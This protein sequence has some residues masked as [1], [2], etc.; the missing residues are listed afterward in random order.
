MNGKPIW[1]FQ[2]TSLLSSPWG[3]AVSNQGFVFV[4]G[5]QPHNIVVILP[6]GN[7][8]K[9]EYQISSPRAMCYD[10]TNNKILVCRTDSKVSNRIGSCTNKYRSHTYELL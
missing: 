10:K 6:D 5:E 2:D 9:E 4:A 7:L 3:A 1:S 8:S